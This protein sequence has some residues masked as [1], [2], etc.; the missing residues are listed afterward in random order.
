MEKTKIKVG[1]LVA[2]MLQMAT[3]GLVGVI[4]MA[5]G[6]YSHASPTTVQTAFTIPTLLTV[7]ALLAMGTLAGK[8]GKKI[9]LLVGIAMVCVFGV[10]PA[11][12][13][14]SLPMFMVMMALVGVGLGCLMTTATGLIADHFVGPEQGAMMGMQSAFTNMGGMLLTFVGG[15]L[16]AT[17]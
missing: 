11:L 16:L 14:L 17:G 7:P 12:F 4:P 10:A 6:H 15:F 13:D 2:S 1:I 9:P 3:I 8:T 5:I